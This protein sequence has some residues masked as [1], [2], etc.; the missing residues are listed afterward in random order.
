MPVTV[1][2]QPS[3]RRAEGVFALNVTLAELPEALL[4][5]VGTNSVDLTLQGTLAG[6]AK[7]QSP[8]YA[9]GLLKYGT[10]EITAP[11]EAVNA[12]VRLED[13]RLTGLTFTETSGE[14]RLVLYNPFS[15]AIPIKSVTY[16]LSAGGRRLCGGEK[17][18]LKI[19]PRRETEVVLPIT[20]RNADLIAAAGS[21]ILSGGTIDGRLTG[22]ITFR[23]GRGDVTLP[24]S[25]AARI[26]LV[27]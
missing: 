24:I 15:F 17:Q 3:G 16:T 20:A 13:A 23:A 12:F 26:E 2:V 11:R 18:T 14:A 1:A 8:A 21:A 19:H 10:S 7:S 25:V 22:S 4:G 6:D 5:K 9:V 27:P